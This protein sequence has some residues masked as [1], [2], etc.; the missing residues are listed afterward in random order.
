MQRPNAIPP[1]IHGPSNRKEEKKNRHKQILLSL[2]LSSSYPD[3]GKYSLSNAVFS[4]IRFSAS[5]TH[6]NTHGFPASSLYAPTLKLI[7]FEFVSFLNASATPKTASGGAAV[8]L[9]R[10]DI[11][12][13]VLCVCGENLCEEKK[14][15]KKKRGVV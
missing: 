11:M 4:N 14:C 13:G 6:G 7:L 12:W 15:T 1:S 9:L 3:M 8:I 10:N 5:L 2:S